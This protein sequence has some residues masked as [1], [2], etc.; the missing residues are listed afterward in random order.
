MADV[1]V[2][3]SS[4][5]NLISHG[6]T[7]ETRTDSLGYFD[8]PYNPSGGSLTFKV[9]NNERLANIPLEEIVDLGM[10][11]YTPTAEYVLSIDFG[12]AFTANDTLSLY[13]YVWYPSSILKIAGPFKDTIFPLDTCYPTGY[14]CATYGK[15]MDYF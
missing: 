2:K 9:N 10:L 15:D 14:Q 7:S 13:N 11:I 12:T 4:K 8:L 1:K 5:S 3:V 6:V